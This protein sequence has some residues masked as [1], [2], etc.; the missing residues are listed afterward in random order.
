[1]HST[2]EKNTGELPLYAAQQALSGEK[3]GAKN[4]QGEPDTPSII[5]GLHKM[6]TE[7]P[8]AVSLL[9]AHF[10]ELTPLLLSNAGHEPGNRN[11]ESPE[12][13]GGAAQPSGASP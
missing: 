13:R 1:M 11:V 7:Y 6:I 12:G 5:H 2:A 3:F 10:Q 9:P 4:A 8:E